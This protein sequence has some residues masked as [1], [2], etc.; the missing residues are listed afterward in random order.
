MDT[1][2]AQITPEVFLPRG[3]VSIRKASQATQNNI[4]PRANTLSAGINDIV[5]LQCN[6]IEKYT[7]GTFAQVKRHAQDFGHRRKRGC[8]GG[9]RPVHCHSQYPNYNL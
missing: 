4:A 1:P 3:L 2:S 5:L 9:Q 6:L 7:H 8:L